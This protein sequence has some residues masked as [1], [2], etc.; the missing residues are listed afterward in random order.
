MVQFKSQH[1][2]KRNLA[3]AVVSGL[4]LAAALPKPGVWA[5]AWIGLIPL[6]ITIRGA[7]ARDAALFG[8]ICGLV[9]YGIT[10][11]T[12]SIL[13][14]APWALLTLLQAAY[15]AIFAALACPLMKSRP[16]WLRYLAVPAAWTA[17]QWVRCLGIF[18][19]SFGSFAHTQAN[20]LSI[21][22]LCSVT[23]P[24]GIDFLLCLV[25]LALAD[26]VFSESGK[27][28]ITP[29][30]AALALSLIVGACGWLALR[31]SPSYPTK[32]K[33]A[34]IQGNMLGNGYTTTQDIRNSLHVYQ[35]M[36][37]MAV[38]ANPDIIVWP[39]TV[40]SANVRD[41]GLGFILSR[42]AASTH[43]NYIVG[44]Y[45]PSEDPFLPES[46]NSA[47]FYGM[48]GE[49]LGVYHKVRL[50][51]FGEYVPFRKQIPWLKRFSFREQDVLSGKSH[52]LVE[53]E[54]GKVGMAICFESM[55]PEIA[56]VETLG[57][58]TA[59]CVITNDSWFKRTQ[60][61]SQHLMMSRLRAIE[62]RRYVLHGGATGIS[63]IIDPYGRVIS[64]LGIFKRGTVT[65]KIAALHTVTP[66]MR[67][68][69]WLAYVCT[70]FTL[71]MLEAYRREQK[72]RIKD[73]NY[74]KT[75]KKQ[76]P[77]LSKSR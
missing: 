53:T 20:I 61:A 65:G 27:R 11:F 36:S 42:F 22:Q 46:Y 43:T 14:Y 51:P 68:G 37:R 10:L 67:L 63:A 4:L 47:F 69:N 70:I 12:L 31:S 18:G 7:S 50:V 57:G 2:T 72:L 28:K 13:G 49:K 15:M 19:Y 45:D 29:A 24:W 62:N 41:N 21:S 8:L 58:A 75:N 32:A 71:I 40:I 9:Y 1:I 48:Q 64:E 73:R 17:M 5:T 34:I 55:F 59:L 76:R 77:S 16:V 44:A 52:K 25:N 66:Y 56:R 6:L 3:L 33:I 26:A 38:S 30:A 39:E 54:I 60:F 74:R 35:Q 23:G